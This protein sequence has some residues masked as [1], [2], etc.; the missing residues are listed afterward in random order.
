MS[1]KA[2]VAAAAA[3]P[4]AGQAMGYG[5]RAL[6][7]AAVVADNAGLILVRVARWLHGYTVAREHCCV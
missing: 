5:G 4:L 7:A 6:G 2:A 3:G 1:P